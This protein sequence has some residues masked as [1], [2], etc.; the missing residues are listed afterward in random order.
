MDI[1]LQEL[2]EKIKKDGI[3]SASE[4]AA[5]IKSAAESDAKRIIDAA[6][7]EAADIVSKGKADAERTEKA[8][9]AAVE[10]ASRN[11]IL[12]FKTEIEGLL[13]K[14]IARETSK[15]YDGEVLK[16]VIPEVVRKWSQEKGGLNVI[17]GESQLKT[18]EEWSK[19]A[20]S[21][22]IS[23]GVEL[24]AGK[25]LAGGFRIGEKDGSAYYDF[26]AES[27]AELLSGYVNPR[28]AETLKSAAKGI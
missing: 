10:Q 19:S 25:N 4:E 11:L 7:K 3:E 14:I 18:L 20:L 27:V 23:R 26:S 5:R 6:N 13:S 28:L 15:A 1:Q 12:A 24:K 17:L 8:G 21:T 2:I 9:I 22:E 16:S